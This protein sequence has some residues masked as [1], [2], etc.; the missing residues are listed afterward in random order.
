MNPSEELWV[1]ARLQTKNEVLGSMIRTELGREKVLRI[2]LAYI[3]K[4]INQWWMERQEDEISEVTHSTLRLLILES[5]KP[6]HFDCITGVG[7]SK[8]Q[9]SAV[10]LEN[11][12]GFAD[13][14]L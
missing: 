3:G 5:L 1:E 9:V 12:F 6:E 14:D 11:I 13:K 7:L 10:L 8:T 4:L 2:D